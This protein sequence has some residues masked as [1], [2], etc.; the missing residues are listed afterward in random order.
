MARDENAGDKTWTTPISGTRG[1][2]PAEGYRDAPSSGLRRISGRPPLISSAI[3]APSPCAMCFLPGQEGFHHNWQ[4]IARNGEK[5]PAFNIPRASYCQWRNPF[6]HAA[7]ESSVAFAVK[8]L[9]FYCWARAGQVRMTTAYVS[10]CLVLV[11]NDG[12]WSCSKDATA[13]AR[14]F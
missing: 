11:C 4:A 14:K 3:V 5:N 7:G 6:F 8:H 13:C 2:G 12:A 10:F 1:S 9:Y